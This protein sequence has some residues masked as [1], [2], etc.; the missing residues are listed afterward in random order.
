M[1]T[2]QCRTV[3]H[4]TIWAV[5]L[6]TF[7]ADSK[8]SEAE[9]CVAGINVR[10]NTVFKALVGQELRITCTVFFCSS[11][12]P[13][14]SWF[15]FVN[16][17]R[18][19][20]NVS[21]RGHIKTMWELSTKQEGMSFLIF[22]NILRSDSGVYQCRDGR[23]VSHGINVVVDG[24]N[25]TTSVTPTH[26]TTNSSNSNDDSSEGLLIYVYLAA[27]IVTFV[28]IVI[29][30][31][32]ISMRGCKGKSK[33]KTQPEN[34]YIAIPMGEQ[35]LR[36]SPRESPAVPPSR[37]STKRKAPNEST[38]A[39]DNEQVCGQKT[40]DRTGQRN[41][42]EEESSSVVYA[43]LNHQRPARADARPRRLVEEGSE[44]AAIRVA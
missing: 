21:S 25:E 11:S 16:G 18:V 6:L 14:V 38:L 33:K 39:R 35:P 8:D 42:A 23:D 28:I 40:V 5:L 24:N 1:R 36:S 7:S 3:L 29:I 41:T 30:I 26:G 19:P 44:Y 31:S 15:K 12:A 43:A 4:A 13:T 34:Q 32:V 2:N 20:V 17:V 10:R 22:Q 27:G 9:E 37:R